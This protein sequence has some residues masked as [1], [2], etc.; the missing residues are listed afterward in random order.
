[1]VRIAC[2]VVAVAAG[3]LFKANTT[4]LLSKGKDP[5]CRTG[6]LSFEETDLQVCCPTYCKQ[7]TNYP[8]CKAV[9]GDETRDS[10]EACC[11]DTI[12][13]LSCEK[14]SHKLGC[15][16]SCEKSLPP[17]YM[18]EGTVF[19]EPEETSASAD[20]DNAVQDWLDAAEAAKDGGKSR[21]DAVN[22][23]GEDFLQKK[24]AGLSAQCCDAAKKVAARKGIMAPHC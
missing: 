5:Q 20:C 9:F 4:A 19:E 11:V 24:G 12:I 16:K 2:L 3:R 10:G 14:A 17:C 1:M 23:A 18:P 8:G 13:K 15:I 6:L 22:E 7:C 21:A